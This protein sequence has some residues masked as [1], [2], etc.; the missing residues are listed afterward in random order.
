MY[1]YEFTTKFKLHTDIHSGHR[2]KHDMAR[3]PVNI[4]TAAPKSPKK[5]I[6]I[7]LCYVIMKTILVAQAWRQSTI[8]TSLPWIRRTAHFT[9]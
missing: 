8:E 5:W 4:Y 3:Y 6:K 2:I 1:C 9:P 7:L